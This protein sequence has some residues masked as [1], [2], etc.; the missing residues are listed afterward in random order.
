M[1]EVIS[2]PPGDMLKY[3]YWIKENCFVQSFI[4]P[5]CNYD[6]RLAEMPYASHCSQ[7]GERFAAREMVTSSC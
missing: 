5:K 3:N 7:C 1:T 2:L 6:M 4:C